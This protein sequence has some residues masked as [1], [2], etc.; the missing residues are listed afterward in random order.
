[1]IAHRFRAMKLVEQLLLV[2]SWSMLAC[3][4][5]TAQR[6]Q[7]G[8]D[9]SKLVSSGCTQCGYTFDAQSGIPAA[10]LAQTQAAA[11]LTVHSDATSQ[12]ARMLRS[13]LPHATDSSSSTS[14]ASAAAAGSQDQ[15]QLVTAADAVI[16][17]PS[18]EA[19][20]T[21]QQ[22]RLVTGPSGVGHCGECEGS[23]AP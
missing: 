13:W 2:L 6:S 12:R 3:A 15:Q 16:G 10:A 5:A 23:V 21:Q 18:C 4:A 14:Q 11:S 9:C 8:L 1:M 22:Y 7:R 19:C 17:S 20:N